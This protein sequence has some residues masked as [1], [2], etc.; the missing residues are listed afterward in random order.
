[1]AA[2]I[3]LYSWN[4]DAPVSLPD[5]KRVPF[6]FE[7]FFRGTESRISLFFFLYRRSIIGPVQWNV[8]QLTVFSSPSRVIINRFIIGGHDGIASRRCISTKQKRMQRNRSKIPCII[9]TTAAV[10]KEGNSNSRGYFCC[11]L[12]I[13]KVTQQFPPKSRSIYSWSLHRFEIPI[14]RKPLLTRLFPSPKR[15]WSSNE[16]ITS[17]TPHQ[18]ENDDEEERRR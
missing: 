1:M 8:K 3:T 10:S 11:E 15:K 13:T 9:R 2:S 7:Y 14:G 17:L 6:S 16:A 12:W 4:R 18:E 5:I